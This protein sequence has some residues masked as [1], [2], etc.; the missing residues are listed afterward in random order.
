MSTLLNSLSIL[1]GFVTIGY[2]LLVLSRQKKSGPMGLGIGAGFLLL[3]FGNLDKFESFKGP[4]FE[5]NMKQQLEQSK[6][7]VTQLENAITP[8]YQNALVNATQRDSSG[9]ASQKFE[10]LTQ[11]YLKLEVADSSIDVMIKPQ[12]VK[13]SQ[14]RLEQI[15]KSN[16]DARELLTQYRGEVVDIE[17]VIATLPKEKRNSE[18]VKSLREFYKKHR[19]PMRGGRI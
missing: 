1:L 4:G 10:K 9:D 12:L 5:A 19:L 8:L 2:S 14:R 7:R 6:K 18:E 3:V 17:K 11:E 16:P 15:V 13:E